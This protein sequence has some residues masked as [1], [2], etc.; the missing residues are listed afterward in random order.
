MEASPSHGFTL[1][2]LMFTLAVA[3]ILLAIA[4]P[5]FKPVIAR[6]ELAT[7]GNEVVG[8][9][10]FTRQQAVYVSANVLLC[11]SRDGVTC[12]HTIH[13][14]GGWLVATDRDGDNQPDAAPIHVQQALP[15]G[16]IVLSSRGRTQVRY[17]ADGSAPGSNLSLIVC[18]HGHADSA[19]LVVVSNAGRPRQ[20]RASTT[21][22]QVCAAS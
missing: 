5:S 16:V 21:Q 11:P 20:G 1:I 2:E 4:A 22:A 15:A 7:A 9:L 10:N 18:R 6:S 8:A 17:H 13:W 12:A 19:R 3:A 14:E